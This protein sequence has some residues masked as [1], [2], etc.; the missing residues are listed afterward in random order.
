MV[1]LKT[2]IISKIAI[3]I[4]YSKTLPYK[5]LYFIGASLIESTSKSCFGLRNL[6]TCANNIKDIAWEEGQEDHLMVVMHLLI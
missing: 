6:M 5:Y 2:I 1:K 4:Q 3:C